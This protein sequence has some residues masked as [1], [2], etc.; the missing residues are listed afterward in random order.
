MIEDGIFEDDIIVCRQQNTAHQGQT[1]VAVVDG[2]ATVKN[3]YRQK[4][5]VELHPANSS[6]SPIVIESGDFKLA[7]VLVGLLR[8]YE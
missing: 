8:R 5:A 7:G 4:E 2:E 3:F 6:M 1:V